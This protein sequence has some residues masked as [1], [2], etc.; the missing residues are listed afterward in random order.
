M[1]LGLTPTAESVRATND[2]PWARASA[3]SVE[4]HRIA[5]ATGQHR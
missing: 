3:A 4:N 1:D 2:T 5:A